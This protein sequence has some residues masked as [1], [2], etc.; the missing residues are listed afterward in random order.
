V[1]VRFDDDKMLSFASV[2]PDDLSSN[3]LFLQ[4]NVGSQFINR[5]KTAKRLR[6][7]VPVYQEGMQ[8]LEFNVN[9]FTW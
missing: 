4:G 3:A 6:V 9:G 8:Q 2:G 5:M 1:L 7:Q